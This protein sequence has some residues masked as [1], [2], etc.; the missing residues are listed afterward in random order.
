MEYPSSVKARLSDA[1]FVGVL[2]GSLPVNL[3][4]MTHI[5]ALLFRLKVVASPEDSHV[6]VPKL[7]TELGK[8][9][10]VNPE[11]LPRDALERAIFTLA[12]KAIGL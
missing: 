9:Q 11:M 1:I 2:T 8:I 7:H 10:E 4:N 12:R 3:S 6:Y 5:G